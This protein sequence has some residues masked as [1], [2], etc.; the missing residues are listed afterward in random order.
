MTYLEALQGKLNYPLSENSFIL[1]LKDRGLDASDIYVKCVA[2]DLSYAD[3]IMTLITAP[4][5]SE[6]GFSI[7][8][9]E[10]NTLLQLAQGIYEKNGTVNPV[11]KPTAKFVQRW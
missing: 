7:S 11:P 8:L 4:N 10:K 5:T 1:A 9:S 2:F 6:G 3:A